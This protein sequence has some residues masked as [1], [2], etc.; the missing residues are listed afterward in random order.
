MINDIKSTSFNRWDDREKLNQPN[1]IYNASDMF[2]NMD[3]PSNLASML[4]SLKVDPAFNK[5]IIYWQKNC[6]NQGNRKVGF[7]GF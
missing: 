6:L 2:I 4:N 7:E 1:S 5:Y 3:E